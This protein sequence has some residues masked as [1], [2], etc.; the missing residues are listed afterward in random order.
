MSDFTHVADTEADELV[1]A[2]DPAATGSYT[3]D[4][5]ENGQHVARVR[6]SVPPADAGVARAARVLVHQPLELHLQRLQKTRAAI[7]WPLL[8]LATK[9]A[10]EAKLRRFERENVRLERRPVRESVLFC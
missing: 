9:H 4:F 7:A 8:P 6:V 10:F 1:V 3:I 2:V 5:I